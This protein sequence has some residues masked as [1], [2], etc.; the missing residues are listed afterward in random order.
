MKRYEF[1]NN[2]MR[3]SLKT[4]EWVEYADVEKERLQFRLMILQSIFEHFQQMTQWLDSPD[5]YAEYSHKAE[6]LIQV[7]EVADCGSVGGFDPD[8]PK[9]KVEYLGKYGRFLWLCDKHKQRAMIKK[10]CGFTPETLRKYFQ[11]LNGLREKYG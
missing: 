1:A 11:E 10:S 4:G 8:M 3:P 7:L 6:A 9:K 2:V 5:N